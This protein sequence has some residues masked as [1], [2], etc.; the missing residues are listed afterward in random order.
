M[1][2]PALLIILLIFFACNT[3]NHISQS[4]SKPIKIIR[5]MGN[6]HYP[7][8]I[9]RDMFWKYNEEHMYIY[10]DKAGFLSDIEKYDEEEESSL[11][12]Y[13]YAF[14]TPTDTLYSDYSLKSWILIKNKKEKYYHDKTG[15]TAFYLK[16]SFIFFQDFSYLPDMK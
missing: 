5:F 10:W 7:T 11:K 8:E 13:T 12:E 15:K 3:K 2:K 6:D 16:M 4:P 14:I 1:N 9:S